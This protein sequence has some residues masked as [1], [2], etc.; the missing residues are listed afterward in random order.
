M[1]SGSSLVDL[2][3]ELSRKEEEFGKLRTGDEKSKRGS[4]N[5]TFQKIH[6]ITKSKKTKKNKVGDWKDS[7][8]EKETEES[9]KGKQMSDEMKEMYAKS[10]QK[11][12]AKAKIYEKMQKGE[13]EDIQDF[14]GETRYLV[15]FEQ[16][17]IDSDDIP[18]S[19][20]GSQDNINRSLPRNDNADG[21]SSSQ[22]DFE[23]EEARRQRV[24]EDIYAADIDYVDQLHEKWRQWQDDLLDGPVHYENVKFDEIR[25]LGTSYFAF[26]RDEEERK[27][28]IEDF[29]KMREETKSV[30][31]K[32]E[33]LQNK[34]KAALDARLE[35]VKRRKAEDEGRLDEYLKE[36]AAKE[37]AEKEIA[38][39]KEVSEKTEDEGDVETTKDATDYFIKQLRKQS[40]KKRDWDQ[41]KHDNFVG[42]AFV[43]SGV[44]QRTGLSAN[45]DRPSSTGSG[46]ATMTSQTTKKEPSY[47]KKIENIRKERPEEFAPPSFY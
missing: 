7:D 43:K 14:K 41:G 9:S 23:K 40:T 29:R 21:V 28:Q 18:T 3:A 1:Y 33:A 2:K 5:K 36:L 27:R 10:Q 17:Y 19:T 46:S 30:I 25:N 39:A 4:S 11:M 32:K 22:A 24:S 45:A 6:T 12:L 47:E 37:Q 20:S 31:K 8:D 26:S 13:M 42:Q 15:D 44:Q 34:R 38:E 16:K 35:K